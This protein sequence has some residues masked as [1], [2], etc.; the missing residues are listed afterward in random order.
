MVNAVNIILLDG[1]NIWFDANLVMYI[2]STSIHPIKIMNRLYEIQNLMC[3]IH[4]IRHAIVACINSINPTA[5]ESF[6]LCEY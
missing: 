5:I 6:N 2:N 3:I 1:E 4:L